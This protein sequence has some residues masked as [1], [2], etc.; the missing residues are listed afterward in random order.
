MDSKRG[1]Y[2]RE[3]FIRSKEVRANVRGILLRRARRGYV[4]KA[5]D[6]I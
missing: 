1:N 5:C 4:L 3:S 2:K 6:K